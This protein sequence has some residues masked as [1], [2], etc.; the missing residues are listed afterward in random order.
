MHPGTPHF[1]LLWEEEVFSQRKIITITKF[2]QYGPGRLEAA[3]L[4]E[5]H[6]K[7]SKTWDTGQRVSECTSD[8]IFLCIY[9]ALLGR[10]H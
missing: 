6:M 10:P 1:N 9:Q 8:P 3:P 7:K 2:A 4:N 5:E